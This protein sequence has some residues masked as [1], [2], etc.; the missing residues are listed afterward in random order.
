MGRAGNGGVELRANSI[1]VHFT[2]AG[3][4]RKETL[5]REGKP[6]APTPANEKFARRLVATINEKVRHGVFDYA[7][8]FPDS[9]TALALRKPDK[10]P[11]LKELG[12]TWLQT[13]GHE[14]KPSTLQQYGS[15]VRCWCTLLGED[16]LVTNL[17]AKVIK[18]K[19][20]S[21]PWPSAKTFNNYLIVLRGMLELEFEGGKTPVDGVK[22]MRWQKKPPDPLSIEERDKILERLRKQYDIRVYAYFL[23]MFY[24]G[25]RPEEAIALR[26]G[27]VDFNSRQVLVQR[28]RT[29]M[30][31]EWE[32]TKTFRE[33]LV[34]LVPQAMA[35]LQ[36]MKPFTMMKRDEETGEPADIFENPNTGRAWH[37]ERSQR[38][39]FWKPT[40]RALGIRERRAYCT[41]HTYCTVALMGGVKPGYIAVQAGH[42][43]KML[44][45]VYA[46]WIPAN[47]AGA[48]RRAMEAAQ[49]HR[50]EADSSQELPRE[51]KA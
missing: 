4:S 43:L 13:K 2:F 3:Q 49:A 1:R 30:G 45:E 31:S 35:A 25:M 39:H 23:F 41:R 10:T 6:L 36:V 24:S 33:R 48:E 15:A 21:H 5:K 12:A 38:D 18:A 26:W 8:F 46:R 37:D 20:G 51:N 47:D 14:L 27:D 40:L 9:K 29:F 34:D 32:E 42:S 28:V 7:E 11:T 16:T 22:N 19:I 17:T 50:P 44:L